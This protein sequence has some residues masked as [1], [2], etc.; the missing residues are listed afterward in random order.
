M[1]GIETEKRKI[2]LC[3]IVRYFFGAIFLL[4]GV[5][6]IAITNFI[7]GIFFILAGA[8]IIP[9]VIKYVE[10]KYNISISSAAKVF[11]VF[12]FMIGAVAAVPAPTTNSNNEAIAAAPLDISGNEKIEAKDEQTATS[13]NTIEVLSTTYGCPKWSN[14]QYPYILL[15]GGKYVPLF[16]IDDDKIWHAKTNKL[17]TRVLDANDKYTIRTGE[18]LDLGQGYTLEAKQVD[19]E[20]KKVWFQF[21]KDGLYID[22]EILS[23]NDGGDYNTW[24]VILDGIQDEDNII[25]FR[26]RINQ[27]FWGAVDGIAQLRWSLAH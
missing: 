20:G 13:Q 7:S 14:E 17:A 22:D 18:T 15:F 8:V 19:V 25:V 4:F 12:C 23:V 21:N 11:V 2:T 3:I 10:D 9:S 6:E 24:N 26:V 16:S 27:L 5:I 1:D